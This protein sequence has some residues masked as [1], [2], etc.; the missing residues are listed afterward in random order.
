VKPADEFGDRRDV[1]QPIIDALRVLFDASSFATGC[2]R[3]AG[4]LAGGP[5]SKLGVSQ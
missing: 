4:P 1:W 2:G 3:I 5:M